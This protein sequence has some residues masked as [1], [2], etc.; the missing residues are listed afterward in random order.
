MSPDIPTQKAALRAAMRARRDQAARD[1]LD[2]ALAAARL[3]ALPAFT[4]ASVVALYAGHR[5]ELDPMALL[6]LP[7]AAGRRFV[8]P[9]VL[10]E[11]LLEWRYVSDCE[12]GREGAWAAARAALPPGP[13]G[14]LEPRGDRCE[15]R[16]VALWVVPGLAFDRRGGRLGSGGGYYD[17]ALASSRDAL[18][19]GLCFDWQ[20][21]EEVPSQAHDLHLD[22]LITPSAALVWA[23][24]GGVK[25]TG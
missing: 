5:G 7:Q 3:A 25:G 19:L 1:P 17:R 8:L 10:P 2:D 4:Q 21:V 20:V 6:D 24:R 11:K 16:E 15:P 23:P 13:F 22:G 12:P 14:V 18:A 9:R